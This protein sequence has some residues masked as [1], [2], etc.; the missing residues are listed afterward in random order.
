M[1]SRWSVAVHGGAGSVSELSS[2]ATS[3]RE[4]GIRAA[5]SAAE[6]VLLGTSLPAIAGT[7]LHVAAA[8][9]AVESLESCVEFNAGIG[10]VLDDLGT[11][12]NEACVVDGATLQAGSVAGLVT[13]V[14][15]IRLALL[16]QRQARFQFLG[17][18]AAERWADSFPASTVARM[19]NDMFITDRRKRDQ[20]SC[21]QSL[22][23]S[24]RQYPSEGETVGAVVWYEEMPCREEHAP[25][26]SVACATSTGGVSNKMNG[27]IGDAPVVGAGSYAA[28]GVCAVSGTGIGEE[29]LRLSAA[30]RIVCQIEYGGRSLEDAMAH[31]VRDRFPA[32]TGG[33]VGVD[34]VSGR[35]AFEC[36]SNYFARGST[37]WDGDV[38]CALS[39]AV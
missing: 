8:V 20:V 33:F 10:A 3:A 6:A 27:R 16:V 31:V 2:A 38:T 13:V 1:Q 32:N 39:W 23:H 30:A 37:T 7:P 11:V 34:G 5:L 26:P 21:A 12:E 25:K 36:N 24:R 19:P 14:H 15:P 29:F 35:I 28:N 18:G 17:F 9:A 4:A 22:V